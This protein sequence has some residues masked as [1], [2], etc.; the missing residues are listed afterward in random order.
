MVSAM[1]GYTKEELIRLHLT[2]IYP[3]EKDQA[4]QLLAQ[5]GEGK[6]LHFALV[7][8]RKDGWSF[9]WKSVQPGCRMVAS[10]YYKKT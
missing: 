10:W 3:A 6:P 2:N 1:C 8:R 4:Q 9:R 7:V 5:L